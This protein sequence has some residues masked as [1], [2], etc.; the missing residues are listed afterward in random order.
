MH[1]PA[2]EDDKPRVARYADATGQLA[3]RL[4]IARPDVLIIFG[5]DH[6]RTLFYDLMPSF[7]I[8]VGRVT[9]WA[10]WGTSAGPFAIPTGLARH[11][12]RELLAD[13]FDLA[14]SYDLKVDH[15]IAQPLQLLQMEAMPVVPLLINTGAPPLPTPIR[16]HALGRAVRRAV[17]S[18]PDDIRVAVIGSGGL[19]HSPPMPNVESEDPADAEMV[20]RAIHG[21]ALVEGDA[22]NREERLVAAAQDFAR[23]IRPDWD[24]AILDR[25]SAGNVSSL[26]AELSEETIEVGG[27]CGG[28]EIRTWLAMAGAAG[29][30]PAEVLHYEPIRCLITGM[31]IVWAHP[32]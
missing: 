13:G 6:F 24:R 2:P 5:Q 4:R 21:R 31:G 9:G 15:G 8:G 11:I 26:A 16:C 23:G 29:E 17:E 22:K 27:G 32:G 28:Q 30:A 10:D 7:A 3:V 19:S 14:A 1:Y 25:F 20:H 18:F 12:H